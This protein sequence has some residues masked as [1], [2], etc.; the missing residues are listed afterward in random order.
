VIAY[1]AATHSSVLFG[2]YGNSEVYGDTWAWDGTWRLMS[3]ATSPVGRPDR[4]QIL[5][6]FLRGDQL[7]RRFAMDAG[8]PQVL[9]ARGRYAV[10]KSDKSSIGRAGGWKSAGRIL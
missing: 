10:L 6:S 4:A 3:P 9:S 2:G 5:L 8:H 1:D 7:S